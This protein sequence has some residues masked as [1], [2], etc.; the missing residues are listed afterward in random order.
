MFFWSGPRSSFITF[1]LSGEKSSLVRSTQNTFGV[2]A[3][4]KKYSLR[5]WSDTV[6]QRVEEMLG[7]SGVV[8]PK[9]TE[10]LRITLKALAIEGV[11]APPMGPDGIPQ[12]PSVAPPLFLGF[13]TFALGVSRVVFLVGAIASFASVRIIAGLLLALGPL[14]AVFLLFD[15]TRGLFEG[16]AKALIGTA[17]AALAISVV[18]GVELAFV[19]PWLAT[20]LARRA[21][22]LDIIGVPGQLLAAA[23]IFDEAGHVLV[24]RKRGMSVFMQPGGKI[25]TKRFEQD[26]P[27]VDP[28]ASAVGPALNK[29]AN[30]V[31]KDVID[32]FG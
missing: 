2:S 16:W 6:R 24:V 19:E 23:I 28:D 8:M 3:D 13:D 5:L 27:G 10:V 17:L 20:L 29:A 22:G 32:W 15:G 1:P 11:G 31:A 26:V 25:E 12:M 9:G 7:W 18:L 30:A 14:F 21:S 4:S